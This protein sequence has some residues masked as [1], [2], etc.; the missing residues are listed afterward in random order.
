MDPQSPSLLLLYYNFA[1]LSTTKSRINLPVLEE[2][3]FCL[4]LNLEQEAMCHMKEQEI[5]GSTS[6]QR[7]WGCYIKFIQYIQIIGN[8]TKIVTPRIPHVIAKELCNILDISI[9]HEY[10]SI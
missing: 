4:G 6:K 3:F 8:N 7:M 5:K 10:A 9:F 2:S 1:E